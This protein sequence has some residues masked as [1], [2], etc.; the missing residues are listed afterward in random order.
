MYKKKSISY[1]RNC[2]HVYLYIRDKLLEYTYPEY[3]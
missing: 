3:A 2:V 1:V